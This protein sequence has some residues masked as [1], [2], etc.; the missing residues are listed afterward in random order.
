[1]GN[2]EGV[3]PDSY[4]WVYY[5]DCCV[6]GLQ[7]FCCTKVCCNLQIHCLVKAVTC[8]INQNYHTSSSWIHLKIYSEVKVQSFIPQEGKVRM[9]SGWLPPPPALKK[10]KFSLEREQKATSN[11][12]NFV[13]LKQKVHLNQKY[14]VPRSNLQTGFWLSFIPCCVY[15]YIINVLYSPNLRTWNVYLNYPSTT[16]SL[17]IQMALCNGSLCL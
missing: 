11:I 13:W 7:E 15:I 8:K 6:S 2:L 10:E 16:Y 12:F 14:I 3:P 5:A 17:V 4:V 1:M 9:R